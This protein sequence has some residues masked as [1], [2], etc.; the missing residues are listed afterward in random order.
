MPRTVTPT[1]DPANK[2]W[3]NKVEGQDEDTLTKGKLQT[4][5]KGGVS[6]KL[7]GEAFKPPTQ[8]PNEDSAS[9]VA[10]VA[11]ERREFEAKRRK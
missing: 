3:Y 2:R 5:P 10:R 11:S 6:S 9:Y 1:W 8:R 7:V 4:Q